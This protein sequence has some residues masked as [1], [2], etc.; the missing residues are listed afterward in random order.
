MKFSIRQY[1]WQGGQCYHGWVQSNTLDVV[2]V[3]RSQ[4]G[5]LESAKEAWS[6]QAARN[7][8]EP[9]LQRKP[10]TNGNWRK[11]C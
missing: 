1:L 3:S 8:Q 10:L 9:F 7:K 4:F 5:V 6:G 2:S 11:Y